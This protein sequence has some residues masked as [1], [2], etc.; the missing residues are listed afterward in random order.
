MRPEDERIF[1]ADDPVGRYWLHNCVGFGVRGLRS[2]RGVVHD[3]SEDSDGVALLAVHR[4][5]LRGIARVSAARVESV[6][7]WDET[8]VLRSRS[9]ETRQRRA[10]QAHGA[11][12]VVAAAARGATVAAAFGARVLL[13]A[14]ARLLLG[15]AALVRAHSPGAK[16]R[17]GRFA[18]TLTL[19]GR[20]YAAEAARTYRAQRDA[21]AAWNE[22]RRSGAVGDDAPL[23]RA[24]ADEVDAREAEEVPRAKRRVGP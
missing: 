16:Q 3:V 9:R 21:V 19:L 4:G 23:T 12:G 7:P 20:A 11:A 2:G 5:V 18:G 14:A 6:D 17:A 15:L 8:I 1:G 22:E 10:E 24:G 13:A